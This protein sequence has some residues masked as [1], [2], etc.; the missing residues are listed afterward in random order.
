M[1]RLLLLA[2]L[3][4][5]LVAAGSAPGRAVAADEA[6]AATDWSGT[7]STQWRDGGARMS[8]EQDG[9]RVTG[10]YTPQEGRLRRAST[11]IG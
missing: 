8:L 6:Q 3:L 2:A 7:W 5:A 10:S 1:P 11:A 9:D 4:L